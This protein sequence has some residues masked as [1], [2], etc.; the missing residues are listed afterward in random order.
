MIQKLLRLIF[1]VMMFIIGY[2]ISFTNVWSSV[3]LLFIPLLPIIGFGIVY[4]TIRLFYENKIKISIIYT[5]IFFIAFFLTEKIFN[6]LAYNT[7]EENIFRHIYVYIE[8]QFHLSLFIFY[9]LSTII[10]ILI[11]KMKIK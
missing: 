3:R 9:F 11:S 6:Y 2:G 4:N 8:N 10:V 5:I 7:L 1:I